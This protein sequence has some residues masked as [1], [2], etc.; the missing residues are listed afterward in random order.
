MI[1]RHIMATFQDD[2]AKKFI[3]QIFMHLLME[4]NVVMLFQSRGAYWVKILYC[5]CKVSSSTSQTL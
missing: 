3:N 2:K 5:H 4:I 1:G